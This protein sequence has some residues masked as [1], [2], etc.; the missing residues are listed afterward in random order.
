VLQTVH[1]VCL[2]TLFLPVHFHKC[3]LGSNPKKHIVSRNKLAQVGLVDA[4]AGTLH[5]S[6]VI[7]FS[8]SIT[9]SFK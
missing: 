1:K 3:G 4:L 8:G 6:D 9:D 2:Y 7:I 5:W